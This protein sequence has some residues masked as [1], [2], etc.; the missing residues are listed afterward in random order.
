MLVLRNCR[1]VKELMEETDLTEGDIIIQGERIVSVVPRG[2]SVEDGYK[3]YD[4]QGATV[5][6]GLINAHVHLFMTND[7]SYGMPYQTVPERTLNCLSFATF[8]LENGYTTVRDCG[9]DAS[10]PT[11]ALRNQINSRKIIGPNIVTSGPTLCP[12]EIGTDPLDWMSVFV[13]TPMEVR[14]AARANFKKGIDFLKLYGTGSMLAKGSVP[15]RRIMEEDEM[16]EG[17]RIARLR[18]SYAAIHAHGAEAIEMALRSGI[19]TIEHA[20]YIDDAS[21]QYLK[22]RTDAGIVP[23]VSLVGCYLEMNPIPE[24]YRAVIDEMT[25]CLKN[26]YQQDVLIGWGTDISMDQ[27]QKE[28]GMEFRLR[29]ELLGYSNVD[30]LRQATI[31]SAKLMHMDDDIGTIKVGKRADLISVKGNPE[32]DISVMYYGADHVIKNGKFVR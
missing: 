29:K 17:V 25:I 26:A 22:G 27:Q 16:E 23:T 12:S 4:V 18:G 19:S 3:E 1:F 13:D 30:L 5:L 32:E 15:G 28:V 20:T 6:P 11:I 24:V 8:L 2:T 10:C 21:I 9:D 31:N 14:R 7:V